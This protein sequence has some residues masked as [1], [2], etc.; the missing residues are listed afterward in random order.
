MKKVGYSTVDSVLE[1][2]L[3]TVSGDFKEKV[4]EMTCE[5]FI[6]KQHFLLGMTIKEKYFLRIK[7]KS[8][9]SRV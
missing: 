7:H 4:K 2:I 1:D 8:I 3:K 9:L 6:V 5:E